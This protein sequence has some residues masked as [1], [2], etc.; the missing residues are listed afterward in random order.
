M[1]FNRCMNLKESLVMSSRRHKA[2][3]QRQLRLGEVVRKA[4]ADIFMKIDIQDKDLNGS[5]LIVS[6]VSISPDARN[7]TAYISPMGDKAQDI[8]IAAL[9]R[10]TKFIR[11]E[12]A[13]KVHL[14]YLPELKFVL[15]T[16]FE[17]AKR[18]D[19]VLKSPDVA[20]DLKS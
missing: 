1:K 19:D 20:Q 12:L 7:A 6:Q 8:V 9:N 14:K 13:G 10:H 16:S 17:T 5:M 11:G 4:L 18:I 3:S 2:P 15:D